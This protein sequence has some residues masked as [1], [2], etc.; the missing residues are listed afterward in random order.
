MNDKDLP[1]KLAAERKALLDDAKARRA[2]GV[3][4]RRTFFGN[5]GELVL[6]K[7]VFRRPGS[8]DLHEAPSLLGN[9]LTWK[10]GRK[11]QIK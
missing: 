5:G 2:R 9:T 6:D 10:D 7:T 1:A 4:E 11:E 3:V 8:Y